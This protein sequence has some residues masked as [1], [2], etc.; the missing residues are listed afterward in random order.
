MIM[1]CPSCKKTISDKVEACPHCQFPINAANAEETLKLQRRHAAKKKASLQNQQMAAVFLFVAG[2]VVMYFGN[3]EPG[4]WQ[5]QG[6]WL[7]LFLSFL[8]YVVTR[9]RMIIGKKL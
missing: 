9:V 3:P 4:G 2:F 7:I 6:A 5:Q 1:D 8:W